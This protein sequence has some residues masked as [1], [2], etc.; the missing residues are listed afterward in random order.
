MNPSYNNCRCCKCK[1]E[2]YGGDK[3]STNIQDLIRYYGICSD[4]CWDK[5]SDKGKN[6]VKIHSYLFGDARKKNDI[7]IPKSY[8]K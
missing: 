8:Y 7:K 1:Y 5:L 6:R 3:Q 2:E 4:E